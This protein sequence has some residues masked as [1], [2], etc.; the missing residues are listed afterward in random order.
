[1]VGLFSPANQQMPETVEPGMGAFDRP[2]P[3]FMLGFPGLGYI[4]ARVDVGRVTQ[5]GYHV[6]HLDQPMAVAVGPD[7]A[8]Y[9][10]DWGNLR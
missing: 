5:T 9:V 4:P 10:A 8:V 1:V 2:T 6:T 7:G 3:R